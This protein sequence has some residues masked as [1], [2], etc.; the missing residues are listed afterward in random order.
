MDRNG[1]KRS[2][3]AHGIMDFLNIRPINI[4]KKVSAV[5]F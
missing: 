1:F 3:F 4:G 5:F 2:M